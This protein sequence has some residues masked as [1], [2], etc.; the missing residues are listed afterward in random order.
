MQRQQEKGGGGI[1]PDQH[2]SP[3]IEPLRTRGQ[4]RGGTF[5]QAELL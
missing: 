5:G 2:P 1:Q 4:G 3:S